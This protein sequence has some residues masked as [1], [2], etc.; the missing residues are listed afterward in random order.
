MYQFTVCINHVSLVIAHNKPYCL[1]SFQE[2]ERRWRAHRDC[3]YIRHV[4][5]PRWLRAVPDGGTIDQ[6]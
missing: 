5:H 3:R 2:S 6:L 4:V 1:S